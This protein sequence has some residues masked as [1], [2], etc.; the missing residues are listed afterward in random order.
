MG[1]PGTKPKAKTTNEVGIQADERLTCLEMC[2]D[3]LWAEKP[4][5]MIAVAIDNKREGICFK[6]SP[7][8]SS[9]WIVPHPNW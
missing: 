2:S 1:I 8:A 3:I 6:P 7:I 4:V 9:K 5:T